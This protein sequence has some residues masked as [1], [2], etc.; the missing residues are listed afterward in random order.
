[1]SDRRNGFNKHKTDERVST[2]GLALVLFLSSAET[3]DE[4]DILR[5]RFGHVSGDSKAVTSA[6]LLIVSL[7]CG[8]EIMDPDDAQDMN[9]VYFIT[10]ALWE[11][12]GFQTKHMVARRSVQSDRRRM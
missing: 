3:N 6:K 5:S 4:V 7:I 9:P 10:Y 1:M 11:L 2:T 8:L 12:L